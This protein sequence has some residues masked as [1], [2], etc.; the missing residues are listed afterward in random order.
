MNIL[1]RLAQEGSMRDIIRQTVHLEELDPRYSP[2]AG[3]LRVLAQGYQSKA[4]LEL[5][6]RYITTQLR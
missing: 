5:V 6:E 1:Y 4:I 2:F 3:Q